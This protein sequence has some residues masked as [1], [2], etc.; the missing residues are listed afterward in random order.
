MGNTY[1][2]QYL[3]NKEQICTCLDHAIA[4]MDELGDESRKNSLMKQKK[5]LENG[6]FTI[7]VVG[8]FSAGKSTFLNAL[9]GKKLLPSFTSIHQ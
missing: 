2:E 7:V 4:F 5:D 6:E 8:E 3:K 9:M 1:K